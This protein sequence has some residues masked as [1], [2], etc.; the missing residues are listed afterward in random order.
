M[1]DKGVNNG[2]NGAYYGGLYGGGFGM[3]P[4]PPSGKGKNGK[5]TKKG[6]KAAAKKAQRKAYRATMRERQNFAVENADYRAKISAIDGQGGIDSRYYHLPEDV[7][8]KREKDYFF[9]MRKMVCFLMCIVLLVSV[10]YFALSVVK[11]DAIPG[12]YLALFMET[13]AKADETGDE[14]GE[15][16][17]NGGEDEA[18]P[19]NAD[20]DEENGETGDETG[21]GEDGNG[22]ESEAPKAK[23]DGVLYDALDPVFG[24]IK[25]VGNL[26]G[27]D[28]DLS[29]LTAKEEDKKEE[30]DGET[31]GEEGEENEATPE[32]ADGD[33]TE[34]DA[35]GGE[36]AE[37]EEGDTKTSGVAVTISIGQSPL[38]DSMM[39]KVEVGME[40]DIASYIMIGFPV[41]IL[42]YIIT[43]I[44]MAFKAFFGMFGR[45]IYKGFGIGSIVM[46]LCTVVVAFG[47]L[48][49]TTPI[50]GTMN[51]AGIVD[52]LFGA[53]T[54]V[55][56][57]TGGYGLVIMLVLPIITFVFGLFAKKK[58]PYSIFDTFGV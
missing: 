52:I 49:Y 26:V 13:E 14:T 45:R 6:K 46:I 20:G 11:V 39:S 55:G 38:Y 30:V 1:A 10:A 37:G 36:G 2:Y 16:D 50:D 31:D 51:F 57:F 42:I 22:E 24:F 48:A 40:D 28:L 8:P 12:Q 53:F 25:Y 19:E 58:I 41:A 35:E 23:F 54:G 43:A 33:E 18:T 47:G 29:K 9:I 4:A 3:P 44:I 17:E 7:K 21:D 34:G 56:G 15:D 32:N 5:K 27:I